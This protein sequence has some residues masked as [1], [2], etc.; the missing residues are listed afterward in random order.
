MSGVGSPL[1]FPTSSPAV[2]QISQRTPLA[3]RRHGPMSTTSSQSGDA[4][5]LFFPPSTSSTPHRSRRGDIQSF[6][7]ALSSPSVL[8]WRMH[9]GLTPAA[10]GSESERAPRSSSHASDDLV[11]S[12]GTS[13]DDAQYAQPQQ[14][15]LKVIWG[16]NV[17]VG[18]T[19]LLFQTFL[20]G[21][22]LKYR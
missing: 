4:E 15:M 14:N 18:E 21:F 5:P 7:V 19:M 11:F 2:S 12:H 16:T 13:E 17:S 22:L 9:Q 6:S 8:P 10:N 1:H 20:P 3:R